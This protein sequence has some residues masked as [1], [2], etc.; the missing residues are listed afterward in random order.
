MYVSRIRV[1]NVRSFHGDRDA[2]LDLARP[3]GSY[4]G[5]TVLAGRNGS[6]KTTLL[7]AIALALT[8][9]DNARRLMPSFEA[10]VSDG[11]SWAES[12]VHVVPDPELDALGDQF[13]G[14]LFESREVS[15]D[16]FWTELRWEPRDASRA[17]RA[18][19]A[20]ARQ[21]RT[22]RRTEPALSAANGLDAQGGDAFAPGG[23][24]DAQPSGWLLAGYGAFRRLSGSGDRPRNKPRSLA[25]S[26]LDTLFDEDA[27]LS[28]AV[29]W[30]VDVHLRALEGDPAAEELKSTAL[31]VLGDGLLPDDCRV[32][33]VDSEGLWVERQ[34]LRHPLRE[35]SDGLRTVTALVVDLLRQ[36]YE[37]YASAREAGIP[38]TESR[39]GRLVVPVPGV[40]LIDEVDAHL[41]VSWQRRIGP[42]LTAH[43]PGLQFLVTTH[44]PYIC[45][46]ADPGG[47]I[48]LPGPG[49]P[50]APHVVDEELYERV[51]YGSGDDAALSELFGL[52]SP[53]SEKADL[54]RA[55]LVALEGAVLRGTAD[56]AAL[57]RYTRLKQLLTSSPSARLDEMSASLSMLAE[58]GT[59]SSDGGS[60]E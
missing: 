27:S 31:A 26:R 6:G 4:A 11:A 24:W 32:V 5:W 39:E 38:L 14:T 51:V 48:R 59:R 40:V 13:E 42:W 29:T 28:D 9:P 21:A 17:A 25:L 20:G 44:S 50:E 52:D 19:G 33:D 43:F 16:P 47:L 36:V 57:D 60:T 37:S 8:G 1:R 30:L 7:R 55:E 2:A 34:G 45:Q 22:V 53:Y 23:M 35:M 46:S 49:E 12:C 18:T 15:A 41:H 54:L 10:W 58:E 3:D 56:A